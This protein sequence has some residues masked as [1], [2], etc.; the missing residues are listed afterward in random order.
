MLHRK[1]KKIHKK[2]YF[3]HFK[4]SKKNWKELYSIIRQS[5]TANVNNSC[6]YI[7]IRKVTIVIM[8]KKNKIS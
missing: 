1:H 5:Q 2:Y 8:R 4:I 7:Y 6:H 3:R